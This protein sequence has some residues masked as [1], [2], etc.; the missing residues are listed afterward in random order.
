MKQIDCLAGKG[1]AVAGIVD[2]N[3]KNRGAYRGIPIICDIKELNVSE[4][5]CVFIMLQNGMQ[6]WDIACKL[7]KQ[8]IDRV[9][10]LPMKTGFFNKEMQED[11]IIQ[12]NYMMEGKYVAMR[13]PYLYG[14]MFELA[15]RR[16]W[17]LARNLGGDEK[18][19]W[20]SSSLVRTTL[21]EIEQYR[22]IPISDFTPYFNLF[23]RLSGEK[24]NISEYI[25][26]YGKTPFQESSE[27]A[28]EYVLNKR[29]E[30]YDFFEDKFRSG[31][32]EYF[33]VAA[34]RA[35]WNEKGYL[36]LC[37]GQHRCVYL[38]T[39]GLEMIPVRLNQTDIDYLDGRELA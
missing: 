16:K 33:V 12:Y 18:I 28:Y 38:I 23:A 36:N 13:V 1:Y 29:I 19:A 14:E 32:M 25:S 17:H 24:T 6:H 7:Y 15:D 34:P 20:V 31:D 10:F 39:K 2:Q 3:P 5:I 11:L 30:L 9:V 22:D 27:E 26:L 8:G 21:Q 35:V 4:R 37:E